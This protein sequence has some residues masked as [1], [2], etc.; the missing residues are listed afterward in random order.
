MLRG[1]REGDVVLA[2]VVAQGNFPAEAI[3]ACRQTHFV[4]VVFFCLNQHRHFEAGKTNRFCHR[5]FIAK[6][7]QQHHHTMNVVTMLA[8]Q[9]CTDLGILSGFDATEMRFSVF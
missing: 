5:F 7:W 8:E 6:I 1:E 2:Q 4:E 9:F 3:A